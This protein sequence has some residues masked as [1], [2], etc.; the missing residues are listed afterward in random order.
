MS[1]A[2]SGREV[3]E[4]LDLRVGLHLL[5]RVGDGL[6]V[7]R[8]EHA[9]PVARC[10][11]VDDRGEVGGV[12]LGQ[13]GVRDAQLDRGDARL[14]R[15]DVLPVDVAL[16]GRQAQV[17]G[18]DPVGA[19]DPEPA[20]QPGRADVDRD[21]VEPAVDVVEAQVVDAHDLAAVDVHDLLVEEVGAEL[22]LVLATLELG[23]VDP[24]GRQAGARRVEAR[25]LRPGQED[26]P[27][28]GRHDEAGDRRI[29][30]ADGDDE[31]VDLAE[32][33]AVGVE[34]GSA[35]GL[36]QVEHGCHLTGGTSRRAGGAT[37]VGRGQPSGGGTNRFPRCCRRAR[38]R[39]DWD[40]RPRVVC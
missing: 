18:Q 29:A 21:Q 2:R 1:A 31:I 23:D 33:L 39:R 35:D 8:G 19:L 11:L 40:R 27:P 14:D 7:E 36:A 37:T 17:A 12:E 20:E 22:D 32:R 16:G 26:P 6:V 13:P 5:D 9:G 28:V 24:V 38:R 34:H 15:V 4:D 3:L 25:D 30:V 10:E